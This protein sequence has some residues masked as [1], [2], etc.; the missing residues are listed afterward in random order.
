[1]KDTKPIAGGRGQFSD[2]LKW[3]FVLVNNSNVVRRISLDKKVF[4][5][6]QQAFLSLESDNDHAHAGLPS[7]VVET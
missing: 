5:G 7:R 3:L 4:E 6:S 2:G 1:M